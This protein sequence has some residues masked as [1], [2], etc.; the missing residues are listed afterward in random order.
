MKNKFS[1][2]TNNSNYK[3]EACPV[4]YDQVNKN[5]IKAYSSIVLITLAYTFFTGHYWAMYL[6]SIDFMIRVFAGIK[7]SPLCNFLTASMKITPLK[8]ILVNAGTKKI[9]AQVG[10]LFA[11]G[12]VIFH[13]SD[14][15]IL[16]NIFIG[17]FALAIFLDLFFDYC[18]ACKMQSLYL[19]Y[20]KK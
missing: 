2:N 8:P 3:I 5:L 15:D 10:L 4:S 17:M 1:F 18:L 13:L 14:L 7:Y 19:T 20:F 16:A 12:I 11:L 9:A 6:I